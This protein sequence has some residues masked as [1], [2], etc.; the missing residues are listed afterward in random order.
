MCRS[1]NKYSTVS[2]IIPT[3]CETSR[4]TMLYRAI[5]SIC[6]QTGV[7]TEILVIC[8]GHKQDSHLLESL[9]KNSWIRIASLPE[10]N[11]SKARHHGLRIA[12]GEFFCF[13]DDDDEYLPGGL[14]HRI[15]I[16]KKSNC[17][18]VVTNGL[19][20]KL[21]IHFPLIS[22]AAEEI[23]ADVCKSFLKQNWFAS[24]A[25]LF[26]RSSI[27]EELFDFQYKYFEWTYLFFVLVSEQKKI[28]FDDHLTYRIYGD[29]PQSSSKTIEYSLAYPD[30]LLDLKKLD[31]PK[32][33][34]IAI[35]KKYI[36]ALNV[37]SNIYRKQGQW[38][39]AWQAHL[40]CLALGGVQYLSYTRHLLSFFSN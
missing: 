39:K 8:N 26:R 32:H 11:V 31:L 18:V 4:A 35:N 17:D 1:I 27:K 21:G 5:D 13:L 10:G 20:Q 7:Q 16:M 40:K 22:S 37:Q 34:K 38:L 24:P 3:T 23:N 15:D 9:K 12:S 25:L 6:I 2:V 30:F 19:I 36:T 29:T 28:I 33:L 14:S